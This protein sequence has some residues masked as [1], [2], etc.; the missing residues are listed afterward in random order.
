MASGSHPCHVPLGYQKRP[1]EVQRLFWC[2]RRHELQPLVKGV[3]ALPWVQFKGFLWKSHGD[4]RVF[5]YITWSR[6][7]QDSQYRQEKVLH[8]ASHLEHPQSIEFDADRAP[9]KP[10]LNWFFQKGDGKEEWRRRMTRKDDDFSPYTLDSLRTRLPMHLSH[11]YVYIPTGRIFRLG[12]YLRSSTCRG[13][14]FVILDRRSTRRGSWAVGW[15][16]LTLLPCV[17]VSLVISRPEEL[18]G[19][20]AVTFS[21]SSVRWRRT[22][23]SMPSSIQGSWLHDEGLTDTHLQYIIRLASNG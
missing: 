9:E 16:Q 4:S 13:M 10:E 2:R 22:T 5:V 1:Q 12:I 19:W 21:M 15:T 3:A 8:W 14:Q 17:V 7:R 23:F 11:H 20:R 6:I 18:A